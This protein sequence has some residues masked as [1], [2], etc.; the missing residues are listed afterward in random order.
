MHWHQ[1][2]V[3][4][5][6]RHNLFKGPVAFPKH[7]ISCLDHS[8]GRAMPES[9]ALGCKPQSACTLSTHRCHARHLAHC[10]LQGWA[11]TVGEGVGRH[12]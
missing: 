2:L 5:H 4:Q 1:N 6:H 8:F 12:L 9:R 10:G 3:R 7:F 11:E